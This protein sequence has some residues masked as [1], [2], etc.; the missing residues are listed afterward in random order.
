MNM[1][2]T[3]LMSI[4]FIYKYLQN[5]LCKIRVWI[6]IRQARPNAGV[7]PP[8]T[9]YLQCKMVAANKQEIHHEIRIPGRDVSRY[10]F[11][12]LRLSVDIH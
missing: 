12:Y 6:L 10:L 1:F 11:T 8:C 9:M 5:L 2:T 7:G 3:F 4:G